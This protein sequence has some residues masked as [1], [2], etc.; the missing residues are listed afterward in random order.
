MTKPAD[1]I[2][3]RIDF[4]PFKERIEVLN[5]GASRLKEFVEKWNGVEYDFAIRWLSS[6]YCLPSSARMV[7]HHARYN[8]YVK[9]YMDREWHEDTLVVADLP[10]KTS[11]PDP[12]RY[13]EI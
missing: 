10:N 7:M 6:T 2:T 13:V 9:F 12:K 8:G 11:H 5:E 3:K 4:M 1:Y